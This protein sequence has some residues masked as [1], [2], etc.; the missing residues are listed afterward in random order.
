VIEAGNVSGI[1]SAVAL[2]EFCAVVLPRQ[3]KELCAASSYDP[4]KDGRVSHRNARA[5]RSP[6]V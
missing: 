4:R 5:E 3:Q 2:E 1:I 6:M